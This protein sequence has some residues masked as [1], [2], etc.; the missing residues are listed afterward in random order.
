MALLFY[1][2]VS[3]ITWN[4]SQK[5][6]EYV[7]V[8]PHLIG[9]NFM[10]SEVVII[11]NCLAGEDTE[12]TCL[13]TLALPAGS[14]T[15][16][17]YHDV[18]ASILLLTPNTC[19]IP[20]CYWG[21]LSFLCWNLKSAP[22]V[23]GQGNASMGSPGKSFCLLP[24]VFSC[25][26]LQYPLLFLILNECSTC[27]GTFHATEIT[28]DA[29]SMNMHEWIIAIYECSILG[30]NNKQLLKGQGGVLVSSVTSQQ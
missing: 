21:L 12:N 14:Q 16:S 10:S 7:A 29:L 19:C 5:V 15:S 18:A 11:N 25:I 2:T 4:E 24:N 30:T 3:I 1:G 6:K 22:S 23:Q 8:F 28:N 17:L 20:S 26:A 13:P 9:M 27:W